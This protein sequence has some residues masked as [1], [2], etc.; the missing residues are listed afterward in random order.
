[1]DLGGGHLLEI[2]EETVARVID[3]DVDAPEAL[4]RLINRRFGLC[5][6]GDVQ[7]HKGHV[8]RRYVG[9]D[10]YFYPQ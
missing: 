5:L 9:I 8:L 3:Q 6:I 4:R 10:S 1:L 2:A 7:L